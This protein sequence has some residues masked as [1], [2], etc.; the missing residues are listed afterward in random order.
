MS[1]KFECNLGQDSEVFG[2]IA[3]E[4][5]F[6]HANS[7]RLNRFRPFFFKQ[8]ATEKTERESALFPLFPPVGNLL[9]YYEADQKPTDSRPWA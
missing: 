1:S 3:Q 9:W 6:S 2:E 4:R 7:E 5:D 8:K